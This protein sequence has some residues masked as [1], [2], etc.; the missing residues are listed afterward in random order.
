MD[1]RRLSPEQAEKISALELP[2]VH[3]RKE[4]KR[5]YPNG[6]LAAH[7]LGFVGIGWRRTG[8]CGTD[9][10]REDWWRAWK[11]LRGERFQWEWLTRVSN[12]PQS[13]GKRSFSRS[14]NQFNTEQ[15]KPS[16]V[17]LRQSKAKSGTAIVLDPH[18]GEILALANAPT[19]RSQR[20]GKRSGRKQGPTGRCRISTSRDPLSKSFLSQ[21]R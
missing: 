14:I 16:Q 7:V 13:P 21:P 8:R 20:C 10:Q 3:F 1:W 19:F 9:L 11:T 4:P 6:S 5:F 18:T 17:P 12:F 2:G 15:N